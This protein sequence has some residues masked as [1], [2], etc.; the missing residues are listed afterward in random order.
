MSGKKYKVD[1]LWLP[2]IFIIPLL[3]NWVLV[4]FEF[5]V[6]YWNCF[7]LNLFVRWIISPPEWE[8]TYTDQS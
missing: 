7:W 2:M 5:D 4:L 3:I 8:E 6:G 1:L